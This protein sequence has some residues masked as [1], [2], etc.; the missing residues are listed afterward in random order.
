VDP[1]FDILHF[2]PIL[3]FKVL[4]R[5]PASTGRALPPTLPVYHETVTLALGV[6]HSDV[7]QW[8]GD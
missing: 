7:P 5:S 1:Q 2:V 6:A 8:A 3:R 4:A